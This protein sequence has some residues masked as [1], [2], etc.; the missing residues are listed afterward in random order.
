[1]CYCITKFKNFVRFET[2]VNCRING[3]VETNEVVWTPKMRRTWSGRRGWSVSSTILEQRLHTR[4][5]SEPESVGRQNIMNYKFCHT[6]LSVI[7]Q[8]KFYQFLLKQYQ[9]P[10]KICS[11]N[12]IFL[13]SL[14]QF[15]KSW[16]FSISILL[17]Q[18]NVCRLLKGSLRD[19]SS[20]DPNDPNHFHQK[21]LPSHKY[22]LTSLSSAS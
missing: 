17:S 11:T 13:L 6:N 3:S 2:A 18:L 12:K 22:R 8:T 16:I 21:L 7:G 4:Q 5:H 15:K 20:N 9:T 19:T 10:P 14:D 1:M